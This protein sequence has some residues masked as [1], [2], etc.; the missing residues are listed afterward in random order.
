MPEASAI[1]DWLTIPGESWD[2]NEYA[3]AEAA[4]VLAAVAVE[5]GQQ[6]MDLT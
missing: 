6:E 4:T 3:S 2:L 1:I 5:A